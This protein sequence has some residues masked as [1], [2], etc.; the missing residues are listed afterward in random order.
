MANRVVISGL[1]AHA[2]LMGLKFLLP[3]HMNGDPRKRLVVAPV[4]TNN[5]G[6]GHSLSKL[7]FCRLPLAAVIMEMSEVLKARAMTAEVQWAPWETNEEAD[8]LSN[9]QFVGFSAE[10]RVAASIPDTPWQ[11]FDQALQRGAELETQARAN[12]ERHGP[13]MRC[14]NRERRK[15]PEKRL[16]LSPW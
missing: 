6:N 9:L 1:E 8:A 4:L 11:I 3:P 15:K 10:C 7:H 5:Q 13:L 2:V 14:F 16:R 12:R